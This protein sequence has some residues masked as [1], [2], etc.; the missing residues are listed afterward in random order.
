MARN[1]GVTGV[2][3][4]LLIGVMGYPHQSVTTRI[5]LSFR[6]LGF[7]HLAM[8]FCISQKPPNK[9]HGSWKI[10]VFFKIQSG[11]LNIGGIYMHIIPQLAVY[12]TY[13]PLKLAFLFFFTPPLIPPPK[14]CER[15]VQVELLSRWYEQRS[16]RKRVASCHRWRV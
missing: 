12:T 8:E 4:P 16:W 3:S 11:S 13:I 10:K 15:P 14:R 9:I 1:N 6:W 5:F 7:Q 2:I